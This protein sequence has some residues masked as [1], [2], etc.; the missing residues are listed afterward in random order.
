MLINEK[1]LY[2]YGAERVSFKNGEYIFKEGSYPFFYFQILVGKVKL[3]HFNE[4][5]KESIQNILSPGK[6]IGECFLFLDNQYPT[7]AEAL[8]DTVLLRLNK[9]VFLELLNSNPY[10]YKNLSRCISE[11]LYYKFLM[12]QNNSINSPI[13]RL[14]GLFD[15]LKNDTVEIKTPFSFKVELTR[16]Q[17]A[18]LTGMCVETVIR[19]VKLMESQD[20]LRLHK[21]KIL[22]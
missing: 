2:E 4:E 18:G 22:Y 15:Y 9:S 8:E 12:M 11:K 16:Q 13:V 20:M 17:L 10:L 14:K 21:G 1:L 3:N 7:N 5:G 6:S 19:T